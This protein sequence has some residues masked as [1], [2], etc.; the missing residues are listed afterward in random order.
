MYWDE[1]NKNDLRARNNLIY[2]NTTHFSTEAW[3]E[4]QF[5]QNSQ[6]NQ[7][8]HKI[9]SVHPGKNRLEIQQHTPPSVYHDFQQF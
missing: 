3:R 8:I 5:I 4:L 9:D 2:T 1:N 6:I 7:I